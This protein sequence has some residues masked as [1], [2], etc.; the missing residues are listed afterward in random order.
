MMIRRL[1]S[2]LLVFIFVVV[3]LPTFVVFG[4]SRTFL[5]PKF[6]GDNVVA[7]TYELLINLVANNIYAKD[8]VIQKYFQ[9]VDLRKIISESI[10]LELFKTSMKDFAA[11]LAQIKDHPDHPLTFDLKPYRGALVKIAQRLA[12]HLF[13]S[14]PACKSDELPQFNEA[15][16]ATCV[17]KGIN[18]D[19]VAGPLSKEF[20]LN[21]SNALP[22]NVDLSLARDQNGSMITYVLA[23]AD[24]IKF[25]AIIALMILIALIAIVVYKP[26]ASIVCYEGMAFLGSGFLGFLLSIMMGWFPL[27]AV[28]IY[29]TKNVNLVK[30]FGGE[31]VLL[32]NFQQI[33]GAFSGEV[34]KISFVFF[35]L[36]ILLLLMYFY[37]LR[38]K[39][40]TT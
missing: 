1:F 33:F 5:D 18:Y 29:A 14:L 17:P 13:Q 28:Q 27:W 39:N 15:G 35:V 21:V 11:D 32:R 26:F 38:K 16:I 31:A 24:K 8:P 6:Y 12:I 2:L 30:S 37:F 7:P 3:S 10:S 20:E 22:D 40:I 4:L 34:Q 36:G 19:V 25:Y 23:S 9:E